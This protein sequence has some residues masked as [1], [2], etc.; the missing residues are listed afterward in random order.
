MATSRHVFTNV[1]DYYKNVSFFFQCR[2]MSQQVDKWIIK[3]IHQYVGEGTRSV[4]E[5]ER[6]IRLFVKNKMF[7]DDNLPPEET[8]RF[9]PLSRDIRNHMYT[10]TNKLRLSN[11][12]QEN[13]HINIMEWKKKS[14]KNHFFFRSCRKGRTEETTKKHFFYNE[15]GDQMGTEED[16][17]W[18]SRDSLNSPN[19]RMEKVS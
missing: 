4:E 12:D 17:V 5:M 13:L 7:S 11:I 16:M 9:F 8:R 15:N 6:V 2:G 19:R 1:S 10:A 3:K 18:K 14:P